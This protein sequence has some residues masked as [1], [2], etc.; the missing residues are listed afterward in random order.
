MRSSSRHAV[1]SVV[2]AILGLGAG[3]IGGHAAAD[4][5]VADTPKTARVPASGLGL[6]P[7]SSADLAR[8]HE[9]PVRYLLGSAEVRLFRNLHTD[10]E[11]RAFIKQ[12]W[13][14]RD[15][16]VSTLENEFR[17]QFWQRVFDAN[18]L[19]TRTAEPGWKTDRGRFHI[20]LGPPDEIERTTMPNQPHSF[21]VVTTNQDGE[22]KGQRIGGVDPSENFLGLERWHYRG[23][24]SPSLPP[25][26]V[27]AFRLRNTGDYVLSTKNQDFS[28]FNDMTSE[29]MRQTVRPS[30]PQ[31]RARREAVPTLLSLYNDLALSL[32]LGNA[33]RVPSPDELLGELVTSEEFFGII[34]FLLHVDFYKTTGPATMAVF[35]VSVEGTLPGAAR[36]PEA[37]ILAVGKLESLSDPDFR[38]LLA[39]DRA[40]V[41]A[42]DNDQVPAR[43]LFQMVRTL[44]PGEYNATFGILDR[45]ERTIGS[46]RERVRV[47]AFPDRGLV[48]SSLALARQLQ[49][50]AG[51]PDDIRPPVEPF[52]IGNYQ[53]VPKPDPQFTNGDE[54]ILYYQIYGARPDPRTG[55]LDLNVTYRFS[56]FSEDRYI[57][58]GKP[59]RYTHRT[60]AVQGWSF[61]LLRWPTSTFRIEVSVEDRVSGEVGLARTVFG[62]REPASSVEAHDSKVRMDTV[63]AEPTSRPFP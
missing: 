59:I 63:S 19:Y 34:P 47:P 21:T 5:P 53:V 31:P 49:P 48:L 22:V 58:V 3:G 15:P 42:P 60:Q 40:L 20:L 45:Q 61:P 44:L 1:L 26:F 30:V 8:W 6:A 39:G 13:L 4:T 7:T 38:V 23:R 54:F 52:R 25:N 36:D 14:R 29:L 32:D 33:Q 16:N 11:R 55:Q 37:D 62:I 28:L 43:P 46:Y 2:V 56:R 51:D 17:F 41:P 50:I 57:P 10:A 35:T 9:G 12:F 27:L 24:P 18:Q